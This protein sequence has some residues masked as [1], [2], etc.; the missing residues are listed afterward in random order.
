MLPIASPMRN[1]LALVGTTLLA[2]CGGGSETITVGGDFAPGGASSPGRVFAVEAR[3]DAEVRGGAFE[4]EG[5]A[6]SPVSLRLVQTGD[7]VGRIDIAD[8]PPGSRLVLHALRTDPR[9]GRAFPRT[10]EL[11]G[12]DVVSVN[13]IRMMNADALPSVVDATGTVLSASSDRVALLVRPT[14][15]ALPDLR[16]VVT[17]MTDVVTRD[18]LGADIR[19]L[20]AGDSV[21]VHGDAEGGFVVASRLVLLGAKPAPTVSSTG[22]DDEEDRRESDRTAAAPVALPVARTRSVAPA[23]VRYPERGAGRG[24]ERG[25]GRGNRDEKGRGKGRG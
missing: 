18:S 8:L 23:P 9:S 24:Q 4:L 7:T 14:D 20:A 22:E 13:G 2:A 1:F 17:P 10:V 25:R 11:T 5:L 3:V 15:D 21:R 19:N 12:A 6:T 16:T